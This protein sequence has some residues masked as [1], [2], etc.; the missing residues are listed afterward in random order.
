MGETKFTPG[1]W[2]VNDRGRICEVQDGN[3]FVWPD[4]DYGGGCEIEWDNDADKA[5]VSAAP[6]LYAALAGIVGDGVSACKAIHEPHV[7]GCEW[8][9]ARAAL[10]KARGE[11]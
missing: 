8:C 9:A 3:P 1:P 10:K 5:L 6:D 4:A 7:P 11:T 2:T